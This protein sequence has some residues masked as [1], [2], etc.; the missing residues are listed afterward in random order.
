MRRLRLLHQCKLMRGQ[1]CKERPWNNTSTAGTR[2][3][4]SHVA[5]VGRTPN[6]LSKDEE[7][8]CLALSRRVAETALKLAP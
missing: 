3:G 7:A 6:P 1:P 8:L 2:Y 5:G 4:A